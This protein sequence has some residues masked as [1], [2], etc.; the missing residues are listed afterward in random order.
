MIGVSVRTIQRRMS[1]FGLSI[2]AHYCDISDAD[3]DCIVQE[4]QQLQGH[5]LSGGY[6]IQQF[7]I[8]ECEQ[9]VT[10]KVQ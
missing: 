5:L 10:Q 8:R 4:I 2:R 1:E 6:R 9:R 7:I 3:H